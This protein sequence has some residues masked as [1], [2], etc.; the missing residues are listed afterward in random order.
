MKQANLVSRSAL[1]KGK[2]NLINRIWY[3]YAG[4]LVSNPKKTSSA[5]AYGYKS[6]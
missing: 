3:Q 5:S 2:E 6:D 1:P 4:G